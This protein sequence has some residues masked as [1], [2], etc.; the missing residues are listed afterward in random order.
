[1]PALMDDRTIWTTKISGWPGYRKSKNTD[2]I[3]SL[4]PL[5]ETKDVFV[6]ELQTTLANR[7]LRNKPDFDQGVPLE[8]Q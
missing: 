1:M 3:G 2:V 8:N 6:K 5:F 4:I 7:L